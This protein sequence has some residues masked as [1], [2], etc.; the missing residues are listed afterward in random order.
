MNSIEFS[1]LLKALGQSYINNNESL[2]HELVKETDTSGNGLIDITEFLSLVTRMIH[3][4]ESVREAFEV[5][6]NHCGEST[7]TNGTITTTI[8]IFIA[9]SQQQQQQQLSSSF[10]VPTS[11]TPSPSAASPLHGLDDDLITDNTSATQV[12]NGAR[13]QCTPSRM[14]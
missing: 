5:L 1:Q 3:E 10:T 11:V 8:V 14:P 6:I 7:T 12:G 4:E 13:Y 9:D 2:L